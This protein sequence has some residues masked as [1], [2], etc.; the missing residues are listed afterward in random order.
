MVFNRAVAGDRNSYGYSYG[1]GYTAYEGYGRG[2]ATPGSE[3]EAA[4]TLP[5][6]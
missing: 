1:Y 3:R 6:L 5:T 4:P 2:V